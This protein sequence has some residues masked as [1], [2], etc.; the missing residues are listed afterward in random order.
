M[1]RRAAIRFESASIKENR[2][3]DQPML[4]AFVKGRITAVPAA[5]NRH[6]VKLRVAVTD[7]PSSG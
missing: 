4:I 3:N 7:A 1:S 6:Q 2:V 5:P